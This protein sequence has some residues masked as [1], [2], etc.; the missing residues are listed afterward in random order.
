MLIFSTARVEFY[1]LI[2]S[3]GCRILFLPTYSPDLNPIEHYWFKIKNEI[4]KVTGQFKDISMAVEH[5][6]KFI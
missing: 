2:E 6:L 3:V 1:K 4:R 5:V